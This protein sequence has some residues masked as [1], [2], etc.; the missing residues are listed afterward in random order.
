MKPLCTI[1]QSPYHYQSFCPYKKRKAI[2]KVGKKAKKNIE[3]SKKWRNNLQDKTF[4][5]YLQI[6]PMCPKIL[7][8]KTTTPEHR[9]PK[10]KGQQYAHDLNNIGHACIFCNSLKGS[11]S[12]E[13]LAKEYPHL[14]IVV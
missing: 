11:R 12:L 5:C 10:S 7:T 9:I 6:S 1:C 14:R 3:T 2:N 4:T 13:S 8:K